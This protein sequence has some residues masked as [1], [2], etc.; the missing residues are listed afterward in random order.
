MAL[1]E[2]VM[3]TSITALMATALIGSINHGFIIMKMVRE[4]Q[5]ATQILIEKVE[6][7]RLYS[8]SQVNTPGFIPSYFYDYFDP[9]A[10]LNSKGVRYQGSIRVVDVPFSSAYSTNMKQMDV[11]VSWVSTDNITHIR[12]ATTY[13]ARDGIQNYVY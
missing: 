5:R 7:I 12:T 10:P 8:W 3:A 2:V 9:Q 6:T 1:V 13:V 11:T 4:N